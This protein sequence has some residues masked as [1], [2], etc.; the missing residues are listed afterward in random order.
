MLLPYTFLLGAR[1]KKQGHWG[2][3]KGGGEEGN[4]GTGTFMKLGYFYYAFVLGKNKTVSWE[5]FND[6]T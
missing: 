2:A 5:I 6:T 3:G 1:T 4:F